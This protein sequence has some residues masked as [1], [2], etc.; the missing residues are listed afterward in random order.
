M[1][2]DMDQQEEQQVETGASIRDRIEEL[3]DEGYKPVQIEREWGYDHRSVMRVARRRLQPER[4]Q[5]PTLPMVLKAGSGHEVIS[6]EAILQGYLLGDGERAQGRFEGM[7]ML[8]AAQMMVLT[9]VEIMKGQA[10]A[11]ARAIAPILKIMEQAR[12]D[13]DRAA[14]RARAST[15]EA[16][17]AAAAGAAARAMQHID[18]RFEEFRHQKPD[19]AQSPDPMKGLMARTMETMFERMFGGMMGGGS[20]VGPTPGLIDERQGGAR[21]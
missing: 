9:D 18:S 4:T 1:D 7:M 15:E 2:D 6:P 20:G 11:Q 5:A 10:D 14:E 8:R 16:A 3:L 17:Q 12:E 13:Q 21:S 19:I